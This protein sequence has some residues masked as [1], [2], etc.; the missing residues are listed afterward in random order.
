MIMTFDNEFNLDYIQKE[1]K[2]ISYSSD[3]SWVMAT[4]LAINHGAVILR[5][6]TIDGVI[7]GGIITN[8]FIFSLYRSAYCA[9]VQSNAAFILARQ[10]GPKKSL[11]AW[12]AKS[13]IRYAETLN[14]IINYIFDEYR[15]EHKKRL[16]KDMS[17]A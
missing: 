11:Y 2:K 14:D 4:Y 10:G 17:Y 9:M 5:L 13:L 8:D 1:I 12:R 3:A 7:N 15:K 6:S 16:K